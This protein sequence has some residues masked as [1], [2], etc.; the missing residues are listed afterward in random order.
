MYYARR[1]ALPEVSTYIQELHEALSKM[2]VITN[3][4]ECYQCYC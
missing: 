2:N 3:E 1:S 4:G